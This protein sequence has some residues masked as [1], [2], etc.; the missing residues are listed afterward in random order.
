MGC[1]AGATGRQGIAYSSLAPGP[2]SNIR[3][4]CTHILWFCI[5][6]RTYEID[7]CS[8]FL[9]FHLRYSFY[10]GIKRKKVTTHAQ[11]TNMTPTRRTQSCRER[12]NSRGSYSACFCLCGSSW[13]TSGSTVYNGCR[14]LNSL[15]TNPATG[16]TWL[17]IATRFISWWRA[18]AL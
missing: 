14:T 17:C 11:K 5:S 15:Y 13:G 8:L 1:M 10:C 9:L 4:P 6:Y 18:T 7:Y 12:Q 3:G 16:V 2:T